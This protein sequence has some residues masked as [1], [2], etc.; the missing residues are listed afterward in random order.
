[1]SPSGHWL[2]LLF[3]YPLIPVMSLQ[4]N[5][6]SSTWNLK[7]S[8]W[9][10]KL[11]DFQMNGNHSIKWQGSRFKV[12]VIATR[13][14]CPTVPLPQCWVPILLSGYQATL[15]YIII[16]SWLRDNW[17]HI[18]WSSLSSPASQQDTHQIWNCTHGTISL[19]ISHSKHKFE[20]KI[21]MLSPKV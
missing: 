2:G 16:P 20:V 17:I 10:F 1:M 15:S 21:L 6:R 7:L 5:W 9:N 12:P 19:R 14:T 3:W 11:S 8:E 18:T 13:V 4:L